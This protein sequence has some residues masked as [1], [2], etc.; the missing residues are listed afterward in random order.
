[1][2]IPKSLKIGGRTYSVRFPYKFKDSHVVM[3]GL[4][5]AGA[6]KILLSDRDEHANLRNKDSIFQAFLHELLHAVDNVYNGGRL[7]SW[8]KGEETIDQIAE[9]LIQV[10]RDN[11]L[12][13][14]DRGKP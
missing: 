14:R 11:D 7:S 9:G 2:K 6:Q 8:D 13:F 1:M 3:Y 4:H 10:I 5:D 12:D